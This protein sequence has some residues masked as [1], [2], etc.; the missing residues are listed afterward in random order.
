MEDRI[1][2]E[3]RRLLERSVRN[4]R[5]VRDLARALVREHAKSKRALRDVAMM[6]LNTDTDLST[7]DPDRVTARP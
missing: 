1:L 2:L 6:V 4:E 3:N 5:K 7:A